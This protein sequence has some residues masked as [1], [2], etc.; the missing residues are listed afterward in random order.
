MYSSFEC[1]KKSFY[2]D[3]LERSMDEINTK[4]QYTIL[5]SV[6]TGIS[7]CNQKDG[8]PNPIFT[9]NLKD[10]SIFVRDY[11]FV[12]E[13]KILDYGLEF[14]IKT[15][16]DNLEQTLIILKNDVENILNLLC[17]STL[18]Y[19][20]KSSLNS[21]I[22]INN[23]LKTHEASFYVYPMTGKRVNQL[24]IIDLV[25]FSHIWKNFQSCD[26]DEQRR[27]LRAITWLRKG[28]NEDNLDE[29]I[30]NWIG[31]EILSKIIRKKYIGI[32]KKGDEWGGLKKIFNDFLNVNET[33][34]EKVKGDYRNGIVHGFQELDNKFI[35]DV[36]EFSPLL[37]KCLI[38]CICKS[39]K[40]S[41][42]ITN[43]IL[44][45]DIKKW[46]N[47]PYSVMKGKIE[48]L[49]DF[50]EQK[51]MFPRVF[52][53]V[54]EITFDFIE[55]NKVSFQT[56]IECDFRKHSK[57]IFEQEI[58]ETWYNDNSGIETF[59]CKIK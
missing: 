53:L 22:K 57:T 4:A 16:T 52:P 30:S 36:Q 12:K 5:Y 39:L 27:I 42:K 1:I 35:H 56:E 54:K 29:F 13:S 6:S 38:A 33:R 40:I 24:C 46:Q 43:K 14:I 9:F 32:V 17:F 26:I 2:V 55:G 3:D 23:S 44:K 48:N 25:F 19:A 45:R 28:L 20:D 31:L 7:I 59:D 37:R 49:P 21:V 47:F 51:N 41:D 34:F 18:C 15:E 10:H 8:C 11:K 58:N 50:D